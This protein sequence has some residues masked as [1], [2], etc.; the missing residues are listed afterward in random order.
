M[1]LLRKLTMSD[2]CVSRISFSLFSADSLLDGL[3][4]K[5]IILIHLA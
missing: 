3:T 2:F 5:S 1:D 4:A